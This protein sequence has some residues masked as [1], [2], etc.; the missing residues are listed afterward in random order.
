M[1]D[2]SAYAVSAGDVEELVLESVDLIRPDGHV[3]YLKNIF[4]EE[5]TFEGKIRE[6]SLSRHRIVL[7]R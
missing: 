5:L 4:G 1:C 7:E 6:I 3:V 2:T